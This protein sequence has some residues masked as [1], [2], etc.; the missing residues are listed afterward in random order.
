[1]RKIKYFITLIVCLAFIVS[2]S[3]CFVMVNEK[4]G[5]SPNWHYKNRPPGPP[6]HSNAGGNHPDQ[7]KYPQSNQ[8]SNGH[9][10]Q[11][12]K[13]GND[14]SNNNKSKKKSNPHDDDRKSGKHSDQKS[15]SDKKDKSKHPDGY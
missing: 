15:N 14:K 13:Q 12:S 2:S 10:D 3:S 9:P 4:P 5:K 8:K 11:H 6:P 1:M 7:H